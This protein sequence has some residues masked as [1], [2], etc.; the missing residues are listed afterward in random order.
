[1]ASDGDQMVIVADFLSEGYVFK[2]KPAAGQ[3][4]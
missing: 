4:P 1:M 3:I 2:K